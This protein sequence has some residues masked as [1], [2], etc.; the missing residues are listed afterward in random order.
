MLINEMRKNKKLTAKLEN[1]QQ[2]I[3]KGSPL[4]KHNIKLNPVFH[5]SFESQHFNVL[6]KRRHPNWNH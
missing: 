1:M 3:Q 5:G 4:A 2:I 6:G